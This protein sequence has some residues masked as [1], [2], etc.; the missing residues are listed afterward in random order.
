MRSIVSPASRSGDSRLPTRR[1][2]WHLALAVMGLLI[3]QALTLTSGRIV[4]GDGL[5]WDGRQYASLMTDGLDQGSVVPRSRPLLPLLTRIPYALGLG[6]IE[7]FELMNGLYAFTLYFFVALIVNL[8]DTRMRVQAIVV[9]NLALCI[10]TSKMFAYYPVQIDLGALALMTAA[11]YFVLTDRH[12][13]AGL[14]CILALASREFGIAVLLCGVHRTFRRG[15]LWPDGLAYLPGVLTIVVVRTLTYSEGALT[16]NDAVA[17]LELWGSPVFIAA[18]L[19]FVVTVFGGIS[20]L[21]VLHPHW[22]FARLRQEPELATFLIVVVGLTAVGN[23]DIWRYLA[24]ALPVVVVLVAH[25]YRDRVHVAM[26]ERSIAAGMTF[27]TV[28]TQR[29]FAQMDTALYFRDWFP[30]YDIIGQTPSPDL[31]ALWVTR[32]IALA[33]LA[34]TLILIGQSNPPM[35]DS[36]S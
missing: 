18:F 29:P 12:W 28:F 17:N 15:R 14:L 24:F 2:S 8:Y 30:L 7:S 9:V 11:C 21:L 6:V 35:R 3:F 36:V 25:Y 34:V 10:A 22:C 4:V 13:F 27:V 16:A 26:V 1:L 20:T 33:L 32:L 23:L 19:Y 31:L 5:G